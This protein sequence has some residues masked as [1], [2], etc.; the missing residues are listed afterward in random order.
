MRTPTTKRSRNGE[1]AFLATAF[2]VHAGNYAFNL[3]MGRGLGPA[4]FA[5]L[6]LVVTFLLLLTL[7]THT[8]Q[9]SAARAT[10]QL[11]V[12]AP[13]ADLDT[14]H[15]WMRRKALVTG[16]VLGLGMV[17]GAPLL[18][19]LFASPS[20]L[21]YQVFG[22][23]LP[24]LVLLG[25]DRGR[26]QGLASFRRLAVTNVVEMVVRLVGGIAL[27]ELGLGVPGAVAAITAS[28]V[29][30]SLVARPGDLAPRPASTTDL[31]RVRTAV[32]LL[33]GPSLALLAGQVL[34]A[35]GD[36]LVVKASSPAAAAGQY[37]V[38]ALLGRVV[39]YATATMVELAFP[40]V[41][42]KVSAGADPRRLLQLQ[43]AA[44]GAMGIAAVGG[45]A[46]WGEQIIVLAFG[47]D[48][49][50]IAPLAWRYTVATALFSL[51]YV[52]ASDQLA[53]GRGR[54]A[55]L[56]LAAGLVQ[57]GAVVVRRGDLAAVVDV[58]IACM[59]TLLVVTAAAHRLRAHAPARLRADIPLPAPA[60][61]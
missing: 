56:L 14:L 10:A 19:R 39:F 41:A 38:L 53:K 48:Y 20:P 34:V 9:L 42:R 22:L 36:V 45:L 35:N 6:N 55:G 54:P 17:A 49:A 59:A 37:A 3:L 40:L 58:Q 5:E 25:A 43:L 23:G 51:A 32:P 52:L 29:A 60:G 18:Q 28:F 31:A 33:L 24:A 57:L 26:L 21:P 44:T 50:P 1:T 13:R 8:I 7:A 27:V 11:D 2:A 16:T 61:A 47:A 4:A 12:S 15:R 30:A 46:L